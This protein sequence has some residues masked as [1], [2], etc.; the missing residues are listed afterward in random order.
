MDMFFFSSRRRHTRCAL[1][2]GVQ[3]CALP[4]FKRRGSRGCRIGRPDRLGLAGHHRRRVDRRDLPALGMA[5]AWGS[6]AGMACREGTGSRVIAMTWKPLRGKG[7]FVRAF[8]PLLTC[9]LLV[10]TSFPGMPHPADPA[11]GSLAGVDFPIPN[12]GHLHKIPPDSDKNPP[13]HT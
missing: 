13:N 7:G 1:V 6:L 2:T 11:G 8:L 3:T 5:R 9:L 4:I 10:L 12:T